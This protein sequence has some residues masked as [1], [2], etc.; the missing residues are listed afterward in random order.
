M[1]KR[2]ILIKAYQIKEKYGID[3]KFYFKNLVVYLCA[4]LFIS[5]LFSLRIED[6]PVGIPFTK[7]MEITAF[8]ASITLIHKLSKEASWRTN[9]M[10]DKDFEKHDKNH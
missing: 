7:A 9:Y 10:T 1:T 6:Q 4:F 8:L 3:Y 2:Q 5:Y